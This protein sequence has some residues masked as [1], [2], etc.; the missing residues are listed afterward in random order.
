MNTPFKSILTTKQF[1]RVDSAVLASNFKNYH[2]QIKTLV[3]SPL[4]L[5]SLTVSDCR[6][7]WKLFFRICN[8]VLLHEHK[9]T[10]NDQLKIKAQLRHHK[11]ELSNVPPVVEKQ[12][13]WQCQSEK[14]VWKCAQSLCRI[15]K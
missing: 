11:S 8:V 4:H 6:D 2:M 7:D 5:I 14:S 1:H 13:H 12:C 15:H 10:V 9:S 3:H